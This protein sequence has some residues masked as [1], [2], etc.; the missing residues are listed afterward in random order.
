[1]ESWRGRLAVMAS[2]G[3]TEGPRVD[4][5]KAAIDWHRLKRQLAR[6]VLSGLITEDFAAYVIDRAREFAMCGDEMSGPQ[7]SR[8]PDG[9]AARE[10][11]ADAPAVA[12]P[13]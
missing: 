7:E 3:E 10:P 2:R 9:S 4:E 5:A 6:A 12:V 11:A 8:P 13:S 1:M